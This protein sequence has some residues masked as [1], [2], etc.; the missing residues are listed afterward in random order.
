MGRRKKET[1]KGRG[2]LGNRGQAQLQ[3]ASSCVVRMCACQMKVC[4]SCLRKG[5]CNYHLDVSEIKTK[6]KSKEL[7]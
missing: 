3:C 2:M 6:A 1:R 7:T 5:V 4:C